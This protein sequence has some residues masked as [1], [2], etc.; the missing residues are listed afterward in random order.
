MCFK[1][2]VKRRRRKQKMGRIKFYLSFGFLIEALNLSCEDAL[3]LHELLAYFTNH[4]VHIYSKF[5]CCLEH[6][7]IQFRP[8]VGVW[9]SLS[10]WK[11]LAEV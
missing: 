3:P 5:F 1:T 6:F 4:D 11:K 7:L 2:V 9:L 8:R 10:Q